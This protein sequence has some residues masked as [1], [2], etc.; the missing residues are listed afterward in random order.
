MNSKEADPESNGNHPDIRGVIEQQLYL[1]LR[2]KLSGAEIRYEPYE[3][4]HTTEDGKTEKTIPDFYI[5][6]PNGAVTIIEVTAA[7]WSPA[8]D[9]KEK[10][11]RIMREAAPNTKYVV[12][13]R[14]NLTSIQSKHPEISFFGSRKID[15]DELTT[16]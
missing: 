11:K 15:P 8:N 3:F 5:R 4:E 13:Y 10:Q 6:K 14:H 9:P 16:K 2:N 12:L 7:L 1:L